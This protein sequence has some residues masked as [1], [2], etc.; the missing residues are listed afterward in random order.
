MQANITV[1]LFNVESV[2]DPI[3]G[4]RSKTV[5]SFKKVIGELSEVGANTF[6]NAHSNQVELVAT[7]QINRQVYKNNKFIYFK[8]DGVGY[9]LEVNNVAKG[10]SF[11]KIRLNLSET[12]EPGVKEMIEN[13][14]SG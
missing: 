9:A 11:E 8:R 1:Y 14:I 13:A 5:L 6:W 10:E 7:V 3:S 4:D 12:K 2:Q